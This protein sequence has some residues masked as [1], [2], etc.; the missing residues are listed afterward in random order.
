MAY[1]MFQLSYTASS[2]KAM[3]EHP[4]SRE[5]TGRKA[6]ESLGGKLQAF[7]FAFGEFDAVMI[8]EMP[9]NV[10]AAAVAMAVGARG[11]L[12]KFETTVLVTPAESVA[13]MKKA[14]SVT[15]A[16]PQ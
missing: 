5:E 14:H 2:V 11:S 9:D 1:F 7:Y 6:V 13:A 3:V 4:Q 16:P 10:S 15:Y 12:S 8:C